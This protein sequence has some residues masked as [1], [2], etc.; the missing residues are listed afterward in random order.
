MTD[1]FKLL[2]KVKQGV[3]NVRPAELLRL[4]EQFGFLFKRTK[5]QILYKHRDYPDIRASVVEHREG[6]QERKV[7]Q[8]YVKNC[9]RAI[10]ELLLRRE[11]KNET[12]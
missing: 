11:G 8:C 10:E 9:I 1:E 6:K 3:K 4:M 12:K 5:H 7:H 2:S